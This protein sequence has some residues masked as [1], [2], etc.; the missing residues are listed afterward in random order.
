MFDIAAISRTVNRDWW[1]H[2]TVEGNLQYTMKHETRGGG[3]SDLNVWIV[4]AITNR[5]GQDVGGFG[6]LPQAYASHPGDDGVVIQEG[7]LPGGYARNFNEG[8][9]RCY[10]VVSPCR[11]RRGSSRVWTVL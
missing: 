6:T 8:I 4:G 11:R 9:V 3:P 5:A 10:S 2:L 1:E 7:T